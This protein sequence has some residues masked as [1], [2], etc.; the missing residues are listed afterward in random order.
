MPFVFGYWPGAAGKMRPQYG[1]AMVNSEVGGCQP[2][3]LLEGENE[4]HSSMIA[5]KAMEFGLKTWRGCFFN[6]Q[7]SIPFRE[8]T[9][10]FERIL[11]K[12]VDIKRMSVEGQA[13]QMRNK[14]P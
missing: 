11:K 14:M 4:P 7:Q 1:C 12:P 5:T 9:F 10:L 8:E 3:T 2:T 6:S 13:I